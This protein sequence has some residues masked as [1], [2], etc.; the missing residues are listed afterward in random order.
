MCGGYGFAAVGRR[1]CKI[2]FA[3]AD[4]PHV[5]VAVVVEKQ[6]GGFGGSIAAPI[7]KDAMQSLLGG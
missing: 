3:P 7:A 4:N 1:A 6:P 5:A 2:S